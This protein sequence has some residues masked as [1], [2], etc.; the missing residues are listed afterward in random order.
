MK[1]PHCNRLLYSRQRETCGYCGGSLPA[2]CRLP[3]DE[4]RKIA[5]ERIAM[6]ARRKRDKA[7]EEAE[8]DQQQKKRADDGNHGLMGAGG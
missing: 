3:E 8:R 6:A 4:V 5:K 7:K 2:E 1:C